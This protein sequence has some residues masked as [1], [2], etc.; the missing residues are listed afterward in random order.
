M[1]C[2]PEISM[3]RPACLSFSGGTLVWEGSADVARSELQATASGKWDER[4]GGWRCDALEYAMF[5]QRLRDGG[6][7]FEDTVPQ[8]SSIKWPRVDLP[9]LRLEQIAAVTAWEQDRR[10][11]VVMPTGTGKTE[12]A[13]AIMRQT[14]IS[15]LVVAPVRD[16]M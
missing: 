8:W 11:V 4:I 12:V 10:G 9:S 5:F 15:T 2:T 6:I 16:L 1:S 3:E 14:A 13:L 7:R